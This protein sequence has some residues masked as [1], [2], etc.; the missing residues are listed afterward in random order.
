MNV[1]KGS[2]VG[3]SELGIINLTY[4]QY[5]DLHAESQS[6][7]CVMIET[8]NSRLMLRLS[9]ILPI[10]THDNFLPWYFPS[11]ASSYCNH[12]LIFSQ[13]NYSDFINDKLCVDLYCTESTILESLNC[14][15]VRIL[16]PTFL[17]LGNRHSLTGALG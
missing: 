12:F 4:C 13:P 6:L 11:W 7:G 2:V 9:M 1:L 10:S 17:K 8:H 14:N 3:Q 5:F 16:Y 15:N